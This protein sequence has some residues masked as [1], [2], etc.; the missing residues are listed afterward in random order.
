MIKRVI[1]IVDNFEKVNFGIW[2][3]AISTASVLK[4]RYNIL[5]ELWYPKTE[6]NTAL[7]DDVIQ[8]PLDD[9]SI[10]NVDNLIE[11]KGLTPEN[12]IIV[13]HGCWQ[14]PTKWGAHFKKRGFKWIYTPH[15]MLEPWSMKQKPLKK[16]IY[17]KLIEHPLSGKS[18]AVRAVSSNELQ[19][20]SGKYRNTTLIPNG[21]EV[22]DNKDIKKPENTINYLFLARL[23]YK[24]GVSQLVEAWI[25]S[26]QGQSDNAH[27]YIAGPDHGELNKIENLIE[28]SNCKNIT[29]TGPVYGKEKQELIN[30]CHIYVMPSHSEGFPTSVLEAMSNNLLAVITD[31]CNFP[32]ALENGVAI[33]TTPDPRD[34]M[35]TLKNLHKLTIK[36]IVSKA[37]AGADFVNSNYTI[38]TIAK[39]QVELYNKLMA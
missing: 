34:I 26:P 15:G 36:E 8:L 23:H 14:F 2:N 6:Q 1:N 33:K 13:T 31:G 17:F 9:T 38:E 19:N 30:K 7:L 37:K 11:E 39:Q 5:S 4:N 27:L 21:I 25:N 29:Y 22:A 18:D 10:K 28:N 3:A 16:S 24:K 35:L 32:E 12:T 20:L